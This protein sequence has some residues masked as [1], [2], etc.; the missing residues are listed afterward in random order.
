MAVPFLQANINHSARAQD[1]LLQSMAEWSIQTAIVSEPY[2]VP[3]RDNWI[4]DREDLVA[5]LSQPA[6]GS[7]PFDKVAKGRGCVMAVTGEIAVIGVYASPNR[8]L[9]EF[10]Q[11]LVE[12]GMLLRQANPHPVI[13]AGDFNAK[14]RAWGSS[15]TDVRGEALEEWAVSTE[16]VILNQGTVQTCVRQQGGSIVDI[17]F[18]S[19]VLARRIYN[20]TVRA[21]VETLS[22]HR[23]IRFELSTSAIRISSRSFDREGVRWSLRRLNSELAKEA[24]IVEGWAATSSSAE[25]V[26]DIDA[27]AEGLVSALSRVC[28]AA[29]PRAGPVPLKRKLYWWKAELR[30]MRKDCVAARRLYSRCRRRRIRD[31]DREQELYSSYRTFCTALQIAIQQAKDTSLEEWLEIL[32]ADPWGHPYKVVTGKLRPWAPPLTKTIEPQLLERV[33]A[34]LFPERREWQP[35]TMA[36]A[37]L[38]EQQDEEEI[39][40]V[41]GAELKIAVMKL[42]EKNTAPGPDGIPGRVVVIAMS[43]MDKEVRDLFSKCLAGGRFPRV[44]KTG[45]LVLLRKHGRPADSPSGY[46]PIVLLDEMS[47]LF[48]RV[49]AG[50][51][52]KHLTSVGPDLHDGQFGFRHGRSTLDAIAQVRTLAEEAAARGE[53]VLAVSLDIANAFNTLPWATIKEALRYHGVPQYLRKVVADYFVNR[54]IIYPAQQEW[55]RR[56]MSCGVP[57]GSVL[58]PLLW[59]IGYDWVLRGQNVPGIGVT[60]YAD[61][62]LVTARGR[63]HREAAILATAGVAHVVRRIKALG[64][65]VA[66]NKSEALFFH[67]PRRAPPQGMEII[68]GGATIKVAPTLRYL[69]IVLDSRWKFTEH[70]RQLAPKLI[71]FAGVLG[72]LLPNLKGPNV[73]CRRLYCGV[74]RSKALYGAPIWADDLDAQ[75]KALLRRPQRA[76]A[77]RAARAYCTVSFEAACL[78]AGTPPWDLEA[79]VLA[80]RYRWSSEAKRSGS[81]PPP[82]EINRWKQRAHED[83][84]RRWSERLESPQAGRELVSAIQPVLAEWDKRRHGPMSYR[85]AQILTGHGC[86]GSYL[87]QVVRREPTMACHHCG[88][89]EDSAHHTRA[90]CPAWAMPR[91]ELMAV[92]GSDLSLPVLVEAM[93]ESEEAWE[94]VVAFAESVI[95]E[96]ETAERTREDDVNSLP[97]RRR[98]TGR[99]RLAYAHHLP[100]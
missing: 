65:E 85:L 24:A 19:P 8:T 3:P 42:R 70:F 30:Q 25:E 78:L 1:L 43:E 94:A 96:K 4:G 28:D 55:S 81:Y 12:V 75:N 69:G 58:G 47:K 82:V 50:R 17:T 71:A 45:K 35:P 31:L 59:N 44:W 84:L 15:S 95:K 97:I 99:R 48:E 33:V 80:A 37:E 52:V 87:C 92:V 61:D 18:A 91:S 60:C 88:A 49:L 39:P 46:R 51:L 83:L 13:V 72:R 63:T 93:V 89:S 76:I 77:L 7:P 62:T 53:V 29:M 6:A 38:Q 2:F 11:L 34:T 79:G 73:A 32:N 56:S 98:R 90:I 66:L 68:V 26:A 21:D 23:Y 20:W 74:L 100:P 54:A 9:A 40:P 22:D 67:G 86:F 16:L 64:L 14:S 5:I 36:P 27:A 10:E 57:Q 41:S